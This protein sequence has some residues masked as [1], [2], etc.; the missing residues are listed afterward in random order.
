MSFNEGV[1][2]ARI[3][4]TNPITGE[5][6]FYELTARS[7]MAEVLETVSL[8]SSARQ[9]ARAVLTLENPLPATE[10]VTMGGGGAS[11]SSSYWSCDSPFVRIRELT[12]LSGNSEGSFEVEYRP[13]APTSQ[14]MEHLVSITTKELGTFKYKLVVTATP[15]ANLPTLRFEASLGSVATENLAFKS[16]NPA[17]VDYSCSM[18]RGGE[19][20]SLPKS[21]PVEAI[22]GWD[23][24]DVSVPVTFEPTETGQVNDV[25]TITAPGGIEYVAAVQATCVAPMPQ[26]PFNVT[27]GTNQDLS[28]RNYL[29][30]PCQWNFSVDNT[31]FRTVAPSATVPAKAQGNVSVVFDPKEGEHGAAGT[32]VTAKL[33]VKCGSRPELA[34]FIFYLRGVVGAAGAAAAAA[35]AKKK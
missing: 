2:K 18:R 19:C 3:T 7:T 28:F 6:A 35:P 26:G 33:F 22:S 30:Q 23:G 5:Y 1:S 32:V 13:L 29:L 31:A 27:Q 11:G 4:F 8:E 9:S 14:P 20:F 16:Y 12:P 34:P 17:K 15:A 24:A 21:V 25:L 10:T